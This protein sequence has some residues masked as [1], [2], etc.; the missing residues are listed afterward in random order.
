MSNDWIGYV[1]VVVGSLVLVFLILRE[2]V[3]WYWRI[4]E[5]VSLLK[6]I[7]DQGKDKV[8]HS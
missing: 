7:R 1:L 3:L 2:V 6:E 8:I 4:D 5:I